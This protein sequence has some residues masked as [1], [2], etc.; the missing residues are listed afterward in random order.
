MTVEEMQGVLDNKLTAFKDQLS[1]FAKSEDLTAELQGIKDT[2][3]SLNNENIKATISEL[4]ASIEKIGLKVEKSVKGTSADDVTMLSQLEANKEGILKAINKEVK[5]Y[6]F[7]I[8]AAN[9]VRSSVTNSTQSL[10]LNDIGQLAHRKLSA[11]DIFPVVPVGEGSNGVIRY[12]DWDADTTVR[13]A[14]M[15]EEGAA[16]PES[17]AK[18][19]EF[20]LN[21]VKIGDTIPVSEESLKDIPRFAAELNQFLEVNVAL[22]EDTQLVSG[23]GT[24]QNMTGIYTSAPTYTAAAS[25]ITDAS[26]YDLI[27]KMSEGITGAYG[28]KYA[29]NFAMM[30]IV[31]INKMKL[32]KDSNNNYIIPPFVTDGGMRVD[33]ILVM[34]VNALTAD[35]MVLGDSR[36]AKIYEVDGYSISTGHTGDQFVEDLVTLKARKRENLLVRNVDKTG[37]LKS[38]GIAADLVTLAT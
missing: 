6:E 37:F 1:G 26:L 32:K 33:G 20:S 27:V 9:T 13:A 18:W 4:E 35:T 2:I 15:V 5:E 8:T 22:V 38:T 7:K 31:D 29:P 16:F 3:A 17:T 11:R 30:N 34:E 23:D 36:Y 12:A 21:L 10:R 19:E 14:A 25:G 24:G 28:S